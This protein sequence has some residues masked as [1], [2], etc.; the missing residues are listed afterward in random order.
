MEPGENRIARHFGWLPLCAAAIFFG[1]AASE[2]RHP[3]D[4]KSVAFLAVA[5]QDGEETGEPT[6]DAARA[7]LSSVAAQFQERLQ[8]SGRYRIVP[9]PPDVQAR[10]GQGQSIG[11]C[12]GCEINYGR[13]IGGDLVAWIN[14]EKVSNR[15]LNMNVYMAD[16]DTQAT[17][18]V[19][20]MNIQDDHDDAWS[21]SLDSLVENHLHQS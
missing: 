2:E 21:R 15:S 19:R 20:S 11:E 13:E 5:F 16:V 6:S 8:D 18:L 7:R 1:A 14:V 17:R 3:G 10:I 12:S 4:P 9:V